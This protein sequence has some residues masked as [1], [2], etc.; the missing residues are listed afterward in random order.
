MSEDKDLLEKEKQGRETSDENTKEDE[1]EKVCFMCRRRFYPHQLR[2]RK[3]FSKVLYYGF[4]H[5]LGLPLITDPDCVCFHPYGH[6]LVQ[7]HYLE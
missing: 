4:L 6:L 1:Y 2:I 5:Q 7:N 3:R